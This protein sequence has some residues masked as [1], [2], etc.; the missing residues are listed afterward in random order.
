MINFLGQSIRG[1]LHQFYP[2]AY[3]ECEHHLPEK[4]SKTLL[5]WWYLI[6]RSLTVSVPKA[7]E[8]WVV[9][10]PLTWLE[11]AYHSHLRDCHVRVM[12]MGLSQ[13]SIQHKM[14]VVNICIHHDLRASSSILSKTTS[15]QKR[16]VLTQ[17]TSFPGEKVNISYTAHQSMQECFWP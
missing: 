6:Y 5:D 2:L 1:H 9:F 12:V 14:H 7:M 13:C 8:G 15:K 4:V 11:D 10:T 3:M 16:H 17:Q